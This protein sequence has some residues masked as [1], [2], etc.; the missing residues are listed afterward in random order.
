METD[1]I[2]EYRFLVLPVIMGAGKRFFKDGMKITKLA[3]VYEARKK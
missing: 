2:D 3:L 1:L